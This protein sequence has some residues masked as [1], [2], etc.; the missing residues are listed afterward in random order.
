MTDE[1]MG[2]RLWTAL[3]RL[4]AGAGVVCGIITPPDHRLRLAE[5][6]ATV[7][8]GAAMLAVAADEHWRARSAPTL[9]HN[10]PSAGDCCRF[11]GPSTRWRSRAAQADGAALVFVSPVHAT[12][13]SPGAAAA[14]RCR[15]RWQSR[16]LAGVPA[17]ALG[18]MNEA[19][20]GF[21]RFDGGRIGAWL[22]WPE[23]DAWLSRA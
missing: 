4:P 17:I 12:R 13:V 2:D 20:R 7:C 21:R 19:I 11:R 1:R 22:A 14:R 10:P 5:R 6:I 18:G 16:E 3:D 8:R 23:I 9:V 15:G